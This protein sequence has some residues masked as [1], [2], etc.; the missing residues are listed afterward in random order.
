[1]KVSVKTTF[2]AAEMIPARKDKIDF[3]LS[4]KYCRLCRS[5]IWPSKDIQ[6]Q[7]PWRTYINERKD[8]FLKST[9][10]RSAY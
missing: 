6:E 2:E 3:K 5:S 9:N 7:T 4:I 10:N 1:M 8:D